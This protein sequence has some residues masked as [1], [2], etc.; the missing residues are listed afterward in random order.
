MKRRLKTALLAG[1]AVLAGWIG[2]GLYAKRSTESVP[3]DRLRTV[4]GVELRQYPDTVTV[5]TTAADERAAFQRLFRYISGVN[6]TGQSVSMTRPVETRGESLPMTTPVRSGPVDHDGDRANAATADDDTMADDAATVDDT[7]HD[8]MRMAFYLPS[9]YDAETAPEPID[10]SVGL[11]VEPETTVAARPFSWYTPEWRVRRIERKLLSTIREEEITPVGEPFL[12]RYDAPWTP[13]FMRR[14]EVAVAVDTGDDSGVEI[15]I[16]TDA[17]AHV[18]TDTEVDSDTETD[19]DADVDTD[20][21]V[22]SDTETD[23]AVENDVD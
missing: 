1:V 12:L 2:W 21:E 13:P 7:G 6:T 3:Y 19:T 17:D 5:E 20:T 9:D 18:D 8:G 14:N 10:P 15:D 23:T 16:D 4:D 11:R 22:D